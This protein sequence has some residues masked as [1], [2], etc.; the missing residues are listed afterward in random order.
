MKIFVTGATGFVGRHILQ[1]LH[2]E[3]HSVRILVRKPES[4][5]ARGLSNRFQVELQPGTIY[6]EAALERGVA[7][8]NAAIHLVG[9]ISEIGE[10]TFDNVHTLGTKNV[11]AAVK[12]AG[13]ERFIH[14]SALGTRAKSRSRY[15]HTKWLAEEAVRQSDLDYT[16]FRPSLIFGPGD[17]F[18]SLLATIIRSSPVI[19]IMAKESVHFQPIAIE[20][21]AKA[22]ARSAVEPRAI[23]ETYD[24]C[25]PE[26]LTFEEIVEA[27]CEAMGRKRLKLRVP[28]GL[29]NKLAAGLEYLFARVLKKPAPLNR[30]QLLMLQENNIGDPEPADR[31]F[32]LSPI[33]FRNGAIKLLSRKP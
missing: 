15:H 30:D 10:N 2:R 18:T 29:S 33:S 9:I 27:L 19:P 4:E 28:L 26:R 7:G 14:M 3:G 25:G 32:D 21:V 16:I 12:R 8:M 22:F 17:Q 13:I 24:L 5:T 31:L 11:V 23:G 6:D 20:E 1:Q